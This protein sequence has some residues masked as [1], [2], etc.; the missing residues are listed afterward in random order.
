LEFKDDAIVA[1]ETK[2]ANFTKASW[3]H[4]M[5]T[6]KGEASGTAC[7]EAMMKDA[8]GNLIEVLKAHSKSVREASIQQHFNLVREHLE[9]FVKYNAAKGRRKR[10]FAREKLEQKEIRRQAN[11]MVAFGE[12]KPANRK[13]LLMGNALRDG[14]MPGPLRKVLQCIKQHRLAVVVDSDEYR[15]SMLDLL[16]QLHHSPRE[17]R[18]HVLNK[19]KYMCP[20]G[21]YG[22]H[23][24]EERGCK[25]LCRKSGCLERRHSDYGPLGHVDACRSVCEQH[26]HEKV[27][28]YDLSVDSEHRT[29]QRDFTAAVSIGLRFITHV[30]GISL[31]GSLFERQTT[32][33]RRMSQRKPFHRNHRFIAEHSRLS[34][35]DLLRRSLGPEFR[36]LIVVSVAVEADVKSYSPRSKRRH[37]VRFPHQ[38]QAQAQA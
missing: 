11:L 18:F 8:N 4:K 27:E 29:W 23:D 15:T 1:S 32:W 37:R 12:G 30:L 20:R 34:W 25:C 5:K 24:F 7:R 2:E 19:S 33:V 17:K 16:G 36:G 22:S 35:T 31:N 14:K 10:R 26:S 9:L 6:K 28:V 3:R 21:R 13:Y 38:A